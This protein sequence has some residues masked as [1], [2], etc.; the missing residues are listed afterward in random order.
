M[1]Q[2]HKLENRIAELEQIIQ[3]QQNEILEYQSLLYATNQRLQILLGDIQTDV[4]RMAQIQQMMVPKEVKPIQGIEFSS[5]FVPGQKIGGDYYDIFPLGDSQKVA[6][7]LS[8]TG[9]Y[10]LSAYVLS[11]LVT[12]A[13]RFELSANFNLKALIDKILKSVKEQLQAQDQWHL[14]YGVFDKSHLTVEYVLF[15]DIEVATL[16]YDQTDW[17][18]L[19][20]TAKA[21]SVSSAEEVTPVFTSYAPQSLFAFSSPGLR[22]REEGLTLDQSLSRV[23]FQ[24]VH[25]WRNHIFISSAIQAEQ[26]ASYPLRDQ[27]AIVMQVKDRLIRLAK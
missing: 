23:K 2:N 12:L 25:H 19:G 10:G 27:T 1:D 4:D 18:S 17:V 24:D 20:S 14:F 15:G 6:I 16:N 7:V 8:S 3:S 13:P 5:R 21:I 26:G 9:S 11:L 22:E